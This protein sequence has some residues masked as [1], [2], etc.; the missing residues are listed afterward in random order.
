MAVPGAALRLEL[1]LLFRSNCWNYP[2]M[3][4]HSTG[5]KKGKHGNMRKKVLSAF[6]KMNN[7]C[8]LV[9]DRG[10]SLEAVLWAVSSTSN[11]SWPPHSPG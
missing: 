11:I 2:D 6:H 3:V 7:M 1:S 5:Q 10:L 9:T 8:L 4:L